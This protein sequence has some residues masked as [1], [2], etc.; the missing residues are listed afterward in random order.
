MKKLKLMAILTLVAWIGAATAENLGGYQ[1]KEFL[2]TYDNLKPSGGDHVAY[3][4]ESDKVDKSQ[5][6]KVMI[7]GIKIFLKDDAE[8]KGIDPKDLADLADYFHDSIVKQVSD[9]YPVVEEAGPDVIRL[10][11]AVTDLVPN[12]PEVSLVTLAVPFA[13]VADAGTGAAK[14]KPGTT[15][16]VGESSI[17]MEAVDTQTNEQVAAYISTRAAKKYNWTKGV[18]QGVN[19]YMNS[20]STYAYAKQAMD[21]WAHLIRQRLDA[22]H[23]IAPAGK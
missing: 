5:Y 7:D 17:E 8:Y 16:F 9:A 6:N 21:G 23:G 13:W 3:Y 11:I 10:R 2:S 20:Y 18:S 22:A 4:Y 19:D 14:G 1:T 15:A 12:K